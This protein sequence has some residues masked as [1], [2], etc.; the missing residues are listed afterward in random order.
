[1]HN[2]LKANI[3]PFC[4]MFCVCGLKAPSHKSLKILKN[5]Y[6]SGRNIKMEYIIYIQKDILLNKFDLDLRNK[7]K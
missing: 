4:N 1:M 3:I 7:F 2:P 6:G 5:I